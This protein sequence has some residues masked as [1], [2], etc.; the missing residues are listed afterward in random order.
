MSADVVRVAVIGDCPI[1]RRGLS[2]LIH[3]VPDLDLV[4]AAASVERADGG[5]QHAHVVLV[6]LEQPAPK[7]AAVVGQLRNRGHA[8]IV[9]SSSPQIDAVQVIQAGACGYLS[10]QTEEN[11]VLTAIR[12][13]GSGRSYVCPP[14]SRLLTRSVHLTDREREILRLLAHGATDHE[15]AAQ[16]R[17][18]KHTVQSHLDRIGVKTG[19]R[20][21]RDLTRLAIEHGFTSQ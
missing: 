15:I 6:D 8:V 17:I 10:R 9:V 14:A 19:S 18:S 20:R 12:I 5:L 16:L 21:R 13:V 2:R 4:A 7:L 1:F 3:T 11:E